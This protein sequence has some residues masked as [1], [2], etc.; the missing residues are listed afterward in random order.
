MSGIKDRMARQAGFAKSAAMKIAIEASAGIGGV[1]FGSFSILRSLFMA[2]LLLVAFV[3]IPV[4]ALMPVFGKHD[5][6]NR[7]SE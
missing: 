6:A 4:T 5:R 1:C 7:L 2:V 3:L